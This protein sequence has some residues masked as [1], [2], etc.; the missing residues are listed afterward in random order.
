MAREGFMKKGCNRGWAV[1]SKRR[2]I[3]ERALADPPEDLVAV[4]SLKQTLPGDG[5]VH[6]DG[7]RPQ[8]ESRRRPLGENRLRR[9]VR[10]VPITPRPVMTTDSAGVVL[11]VRE[12]P[13]YR[14]PRRAAGSDAE[15]EQLQHAACE[16]PILLDL[17][18][19]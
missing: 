17:M 15:I 2:E 18:S 19:Q 11:V 3:R 10:G 13:G 5:F 7:E 6:H 16:K 9:H 8:V 14:S 1:V 4:P 12:G